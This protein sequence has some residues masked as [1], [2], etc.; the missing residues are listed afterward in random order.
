MNIDCA[1]G[2]KMRV[3]T[4]LSEGRHPQRNLYGN[5]PMG[6]ENRTAARNRPNSVLPD[7]KI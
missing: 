4:F 1:G 7:E 6:T 3:I 2:Q 5:T